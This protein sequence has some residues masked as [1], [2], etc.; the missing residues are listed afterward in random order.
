L[1]FAPLVLWLLVNAVISLKLPGA[2]FFVL[3]LFFAMAG[4]QFH[5]GSRQ[6]GTALLL[7]TTALAVPHVMIFAP[8]VP[9][10]VIGLGLKMMLIGTLLACFSLLLLLPVFCHYPSLNRLAGGAVIVSLACFVIS[11]GQADYS[12][13]RRKPNSINYVYDRDS[14][15][16][17]MISS[18]HSWDEYI[19]QLID[20]VQE[21][22]PWDT[23]IY[24]ETKRE[25]VRFNQQTEVLDLAAADVRIVK[26]EFS[27][28]HRTLSFSIS[29]R[30]ATNQ[31]RLATN[32][33]LHV[34]SLSV[35]NQLFS[36]K[37]GILS[38][39]IE[40]GFFFYYFM[41]TPYEK[42]T[43]ELTVPK[44]S[45]LS[46]KVYEV[47]FDLLEQRDDLKPRSALS[48]PTPSH[49]SDA[50]IIGQSVTTP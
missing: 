4:Y 18:N 20:P 43:V 32:N 46:L 6:T 12:P 38:R 31:I 21:V 49:V 42:I 19:G 25:K 23:S 30:R 16:A 27:G 29:P 26:D 41:A 35:N 48:M 1:F 7:V 37:Q 34:T 10:L 24:P 5:L 22:E 45:E 39:E 13:E 11:A 15:R 33:P 17:F 36:N 3:P 44:T 2:G 28:E 14:E 40:A 9:L 47:A 8:L 50:T